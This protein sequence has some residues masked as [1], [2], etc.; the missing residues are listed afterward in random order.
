M[1]ATHVEIQTNLKQAGSIINVRKETIK[2]KKIQIE[3]QNTEFRAHSANWRNFLVNQTHRSSAYAFC[4]EQLVAFVFLLIFQGNFSRGKLRMQEGTLQCK[5]ECFQGRAGVYA[6][7]VLV[8]VF[9]PKF[10][11]RSAKMRLTE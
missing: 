10:Y 5:V 2:E 1:V 9:P 3:K 8:S 11:C 7:V 4:Q 6:V